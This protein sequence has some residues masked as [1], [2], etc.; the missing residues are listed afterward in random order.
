MAIS[1]KTVPLYKSNEGKCQNQEKGLEMEGNH[2]PEPWWFQELC[3]FR[4]L[5]S[6]Q[7]VELKGRHVC[8]LKNKKLNTE[9]F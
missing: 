4:S 6:L 9:C 3:T 8:G 1:L 5:I 2:S 7:V